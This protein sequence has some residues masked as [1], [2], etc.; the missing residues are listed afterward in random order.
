MKRNFFLLVFLSLTGFVTSFGSYIVAANLPAY[1]RETGAGL[2]VIGILIALYDVAEI[3]VKPIGALLSRRWGEWSILRIGLMLFALA[4]GIYLIFPPQWLIV[5]RLAQ[6]AGAAFFS[7][8]SITLL[9]R[10][11][12]DKKGAALGIYGAV[13]NAGYVLAPTIGGIL[14]YR[15]GFRSV[16]VI[17]L[18]VGLLVIIL[19]YLVRPRLYPSGQLIP[20]NKWKKSAGPRDLFNSLK[21]RQTLP[22]FLIMFFNM[23]FMAA[24]FGFMPVFLSG[25]GLDSLEAGIVLAGNAMVYLSIQPFAGRLSDTFGRKKLMALGLST[26]TLS[27]MLIT[28]FS[29]PF[30]LIFSGTLAVG[31]G[32]VSP[33][34]DAFV[35]DVSDPDDLAINLGI[36]GSYK[37]VGE[38]VGPLA[39]G[40]IGQTMGLDWAFILVGLLGLVSLICIVFLRGQKPAHS[41]EFVHL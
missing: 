23:I 22:I 4:S 18:G 2:I 39:M 33:L 37:E 8:M 5:V 27:I 30:Y 12:T 40:F 31:I 6:G 13:K 34:G 41:I 38:M 17:C 28:F 16:F 15:S 3:L 1:S 25:K 11:F 19:S 20:G 21:N 32:W 35:G 36:A 24:F 26:A 29:H 9:I 7:V 10:Y 14:V